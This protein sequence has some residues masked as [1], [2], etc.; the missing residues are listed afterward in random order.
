MYSQDN[1]SQQKIRYAVVGL[2]WIAQEDILPA[3]DHAQSNSEVVALVSG[4]PTKMDALRQKYDVQ[5]CYSYEEYEA[6]LQ[7]K[8][9]DAVYI[10]LPNHLHCEYAIKAAEAGIHILCEKPMAVTEDECRRMMESAQQNNV[11][12][13]IA[14]RLHFDQANMEAVRIAQS[15]EIGEPRIFNSTFC[16]Q[17][18]EGN[19]RL[20]SVA[21]GGGT[22][23]DMGV[24]C[25][26]AA[27]YLFRQ[28]PI[29]VTSFSAS[30]GES[31]FAQCD[32]MT[33]AILRFP[34]DRLATFT[35]S[36]GAASVSTYQI[37][38]TTGSVQMESAYSYL[39]DLKQ[40]ISV[41][42]QKREHSF[43][44]GDQFAAEILYFSDCVVADREPEPSGK[45]GL[46]D[47]RVIRAIYESARLG[48]PVHLD[49]FQH[50]QRPSVGQVIQRPPQE[51]LPGLVNAADPS[52]NS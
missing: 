49:D 15:G 48:R 8:T 12:L 20:E 47:V 35:S 45:E 38:G 37:I 2:G 33:S 18:V 39:G 22:V 28:E 17:V 31:R 19:V 3:F 36:F 16:Q 25:I 44:A 50:A 10:A 13:M 6:C 40:E 30:N 27:R 1:Q 42:G 51:K 43:P 24:Y 46:A 52:G 5:H 4:D 26:N 34:G 14:Y 29:E 9:I 23:Y 21:Q 7:S 11:K 32:E 41:N